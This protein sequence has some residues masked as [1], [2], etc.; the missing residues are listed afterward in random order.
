MNFSRHPVVGCVDS[1]KRHGIR[2]PTIQDGEAMVKVCYEL[3][4][5]NTAKP[6][7]KDDKLLILILMRQP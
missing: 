1:K 6:N 4:A 3:E 5:I 7:L 2:E